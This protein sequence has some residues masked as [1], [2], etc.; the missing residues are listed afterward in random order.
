MCILVSRCENVI[1]WGCLRR[2]RYTYMW[3]DGGRENIWSTHGYCLFTDWFIT[4]RLFFK[5]SLR[6]FEIQIE[7]QII[8]FIVQYFWVQGSIIHTIR[9]L[10]DLIS[11]FRLIS[12]KMFQLETLKLPEVLVI[13]AL[14]LIEHNNFAKSS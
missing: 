6:K 13:S 11:N 8:F 7:N 9:N 2:S 1:Q 5:P 14:A 10:K 12:S 4:Y 3:W